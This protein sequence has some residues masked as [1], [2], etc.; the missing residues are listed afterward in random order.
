MLARQCPTRNRFGEL[1]IANF[2]NA[3]PIMTRARPVYDMSWCCLTEGQQCASK[4]NS[5]TPAA[6]AAVYGQLNRKAVV[7]KT[8]RLM[9]GTL[10]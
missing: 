10:G 1:T 3:S 9:E 6:M 7:E 4:R 2:L 8:L 5:V